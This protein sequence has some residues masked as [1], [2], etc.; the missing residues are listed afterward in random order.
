V[1][2]SPIAEAFDDLGLVTERLAGYCVPQRRFA[3]DE[4]REAAIA[5]LRARGLD[6][7][8]ELRLGAHCAELYVSRPPEAVRAAP[9]E[10]ILGS[11]A[12]G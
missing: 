9:I 12:A 2:F 5:G 7:T 10:D 8:P 1:D 3:H 4:E 6:P 11:L